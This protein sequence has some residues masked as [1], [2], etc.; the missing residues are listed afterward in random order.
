MPPK[1]PAKKVDEFGFSRDSIARITGDENDLL[2]DLSKD[3]PFE[4]SAAEIDDS[5]VDQMLAE[6]I[7]EYMKEVPMD[8]NGQI[9]D[10]SDSPQI[11]AGIESVAKYLNLVK[12]LTEIHLGNCEINDPGA[13]ILFRA[14]AS[15]KQ[16]QKVNLD[17]NNLTDACLEEL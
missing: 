4:M 3:D 17:N 6:Q 12:S 16:L 7:K 15:H 11:G 8:K 10:M 14:L 9:V 2:S 1:A 5:N 13:K